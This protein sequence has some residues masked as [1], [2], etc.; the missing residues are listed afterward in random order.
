MVVHRD[1]Q[2]HTSDYTSDAQETRWYL[3]RLMLGVYSKLYINF[4]TPIEHF[5]Y[6]FKKEYLSKDLMER[7][8][9]F[10]GHRR[11]SH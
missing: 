9:L 5:Y 10:L 3:I 1:F 4:W 2:D 7:V 6:I 8:N 11:L